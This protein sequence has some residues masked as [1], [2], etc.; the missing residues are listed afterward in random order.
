MSSAE[1]S[2]IVQ[3]SE[4]TSRMR[5]EGPDVIA[6]KTVERDFPTPSHVLEAAT[7]AMKRGETRFTAM[8]GAIEVR[9]AIYK[10]AMP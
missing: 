7:D 1:P 9:Q 2:E 4:R 3:I 6:L 10:A 5:A 8:G